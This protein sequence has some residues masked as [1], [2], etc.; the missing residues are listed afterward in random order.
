[1]SRFAFG[2][3]VRSP[4]DVCDFPIGKA[5]YAMNNA[6][7]GRLCLPAGDLANRGDKDRNKS[8]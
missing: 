3:P 1:M 5:F 2:F 7:R 4:V 8:V 6:D